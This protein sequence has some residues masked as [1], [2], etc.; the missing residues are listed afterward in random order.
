MML[1]QNSSAAG[2]FCDA[3]IRL[4]LRSWSVMHTVRYAERYICAHALERNV[5]LRQGIIG[6]VGGCWRGRTKARYERDT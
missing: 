2:G 1:Y 4:T 6:L 5:R 3:Y